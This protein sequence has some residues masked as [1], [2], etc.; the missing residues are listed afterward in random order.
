MA[1]NLPRPYPDLI[2]VAWKSVKSLF[3]NQFQFLD[4]G[5]RRNDEPFLP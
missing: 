3:N 1:N 5:L 4:S 2:E